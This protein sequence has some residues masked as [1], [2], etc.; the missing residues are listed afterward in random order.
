MVGTSSFLDAPANLVVFSHNATELRD[1]RAGLLVGGAASHAVL[2][3][4]CSLNL[5]S[6]AP[7]VDVLILGAGITGVNAARR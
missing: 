7:E 2:S 1:A 3:A 4:S 5:Y 6:R